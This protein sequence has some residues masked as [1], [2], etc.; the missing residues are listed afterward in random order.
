[1]IR[2]TSASASADED[3]SQYY[4]NSDLIY[5]MS[6][7]SNIHPY[8]Y[9]NNINWTIDDYRYKLN[10]SKI[11][12][13]YYD[14]T[15]IIYG[16]DPI[17]NIIPRENFTK[18]TEF[19]V[20][21]GSEYIYAIETKKVEGK[22]SS[23][24]YISHVVVIDID[25]NI[26][27]YS[28]DIKSNQIIVSLNKLF[29]FEYITLLK[30]YDYKST[31]G[32]RLTVDSSY[33]EA[34]VVVPYSYNNSNYMSK[35]FE[36]IEGWE[37]SDINI[38]GQLSNTN[39]YN[40]SDDKY[41]SK[42]DNGY[43]FIGDRV[44]YLSNEIEI[45]DNEEK[46]EMIKDG[47][48]DIATITV[49]TAVEAAAE[50]I[51]PVLGPILATLDTGIDISIGLVKIVYG[52]SENDYKIIHNTY[53]SEDYFSSEPHEF[54]TTSDG[55]IKEYGGLIKTE[56]TSLN[57]ISL[58][59]CGDHVKSL[60]HY[61][62]SEEET[63]TNFTQVL[64][65][66]INGKQVVS[67]KTS[68]IGEKKTTYNTCDYISNEINTIGSKSTYEF[69]P[70]YSQAY[71]INCGDN[72]VSVYEDGKENKINSINVV[73]LEK[74]VR[75]NIVVEN[76][77]EALILY[78]FYISGYD[79]NEEIS[80]KP[81][82]TI[83]YTYISDKEGIYY[84]ESKLDLEIINEDYDI[85]LLQKDKIYNI[86]VT[87]N[88]NQNVTSNLELK[89]PE[90]IDL[91]DDGVIQSDSKY[92][93]LTDGEGIYQLTFNGVDKKHYF[94][95]GNSFET[96]INTL[97]SIGNVK[98]YFE[99]SKLQSIKKLSA[100]QLLLI[101]NK[102][103]SNGDSYYTF[104]NELSVELDD[105]INDN[106]D[107][108]FEVY[109]AYCGISNIYDYERK[110]IIFEEKNYGKHET[111]IEI[112]VTLNSK[113]LPA[114]NM[115]VNFY[116]LE[117]Q[118]TIKVNKEIEGLNIKYTFYFEGDLSLNSL[119]GSVKSVWDGKTFGNEGKI[120]FDKTILSRYK[121]NIN[122]NVKEEYLDYVLSKMKVT[123]VYTYN[124]SEHVNGSECT[125][126]YNYNKNKYEYKYKMVEDEDLSSFTLL[127]SMFD[128]IEY[129]NMRDKK[130]SYS[131]TMGIST[132]DQLE[133][134]LTDYIDDSFSYSDEYNSDI[135]IKGK[136]NR[137]SYALLKDIN[138]YGRTIEIDENVMFI[139]ELSGK[140]NNGIRYTISNLTIK[141]TTDANAMGI[142]FEN[143]GYIHDIEFKDCTYNL[144]D[145]H[146]YNTFNNKKIYKTMI[147]FL[148]PSNYGTIE[149]VKLSSITCYYKDTE[150]NI[151]HKIVT[152]CNC[153]NF[154]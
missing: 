46:N 8:T 129:Y 94:F 49:E 103:Y 76:K 66:K 35:G 64:T 151:K 2:G 74:D 109:S 110:K 19:K 7:T 38:I 32:L 17:V 141:R 142:F 4:E 18:E 80:I 139:G 43:F 55:Q 138:C 69:T 40:Q 73:C 78:D 87:N 154:S 92:V 131:Y 96:Q 28:Y 26:E 31:I 45:V 148:C 132:F 75:Y 30:E 65:F 102:Q 21:C 143:Y 25:N 42:E 52:F 146:V 125:D 135:E 47:I 95:D 15:T 10:A 48:T 24:C 91:D 121:F 22:D 100:E 29:E 79:I 145:V 12:Y 149:N 16:D 116:Y 153:I 82:E 62:S 44:E 34:D 39:D 101:E 63:P 128:V 107:L 3:L 50:A 120:E 41:V 93:K 117:G 60:F 54:M 98:Y 97:I 88:S 106:S 5:D 86:L 130:C 67:S 124:G 56:V 85:L 53:T 122:W 1:M 115:Y 20:V 113:L 90:E 123:Y 51:N 105:S 114:L 136:L 134:A 27:E 37:I 104:D 118:A 147:S 9:K 83:L 13:S 150:N 99:T 72:E 77:S 71:T 152:N 89:N 81:N 119:N 108:K 111:N 61:S 57:K 140:G 33:E 126:I 14:S 11:E 23:T 137:Y 59:Q 84:F 36:N 70:S 68:H 144:I 6:D 58:Q 127:V 133:Y 112:V